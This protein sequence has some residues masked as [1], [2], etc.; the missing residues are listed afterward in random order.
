MELELAL[1]LLAVSNLITIIAV[2]S[3]IRMRFSIERAKKIVAKAVGQQALLKQTIASPEARA[4]R[5][6][7][8][9]AK[10]KS[11]K[12]KG[13][14]F[15]SKQRGYVSRQ[16]LRQFPNLSEK[17]IDALI[18]KSLKLLKAYGD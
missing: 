5:Y 12:G 11:L 13:R 3:W 16:L 4:L 14:A 18:K 1:T 6:V 7:T 9:A 8:A 17:Q 2:V 10:N 15:S